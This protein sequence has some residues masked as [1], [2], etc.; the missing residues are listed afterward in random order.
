MQKFTKLYSPRTRS[1]PLHG[2]HVEHSGEGAF[3]NLNNKDPEMGENKMK[4]SIKLTQSGFQYFSYNENSIMVFLSGKPISAAINEL[5]KYMKEEIGD[6]MPEKVFGKKYLGNGKIFNIFRGNCSRA[7]AFQFESIEKAMEAFKQ[8]RWEKEGMKEKAK[9][10]SG[11][12]WLG[13]IV[14]DEFQPLEKPVMQL[15]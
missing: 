10:F 12:M 3:F 11:N 14:N 5:P 2:C 1:H 9:V 13:N 7:I 15:L 4:N 8:I 6:A